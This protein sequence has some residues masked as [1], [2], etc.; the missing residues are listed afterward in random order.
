MIWVRESE[1]GDSDRTYYHKFR[2]IEQAAIFISGVEVGVSQLQII[3]EL[4]ETRVFEG[5]YRMWVLGQEPNI[6]D[7]LKHA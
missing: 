5:E 7:H 3:E 1:P 4:G 6:E 2:D